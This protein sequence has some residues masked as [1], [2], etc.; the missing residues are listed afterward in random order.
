MLLI[1]GHIDAIK[2]AVRA[3]IRDDSHPIGRKL[4]E[5]LEERVRAFAA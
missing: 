3:D 4:A 1:D 2:A 5:E